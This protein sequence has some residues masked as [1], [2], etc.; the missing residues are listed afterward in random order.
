MG[1]EEL[2]DKRLPRYMNPPEDKLER[3]LLRLISRHPALRL[4]QYAEQQG[5]PPGGH[6]CFKVRLK[7]KH[8]RGCRL[9]Q[10]G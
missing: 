7:L 3:S 10:A 2:L 8:G 1:S 5:V 4:Q 6:L 9:E